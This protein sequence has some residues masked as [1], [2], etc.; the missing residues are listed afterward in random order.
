MQT[1]SLHIKTNKAV[2][3]DVSKLPV[4]R[5][6][7]RMLYFA[8]FNSKPGAEVKPSIY[9]T[10]VSLVC[11]SDSVCNIS[12]WTKILGHLQKCISKVEQVRKVV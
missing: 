3:R 4:I 11:A 7:Q 8:T 5:S 12:T 10:V 2:A 9:G 1:I 6:P